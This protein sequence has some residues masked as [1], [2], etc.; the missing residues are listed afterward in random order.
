MC[1]LPVG[2][3][4]VLQY[5][6]IMNLAGGG[7][8]YGSFPHPPDSWEWF[9]C[10]GHRHFR[11]ERHAV[12]KFRL[13][14]G[15]S[16]GSV[17]TRRAICLHRLPLVACAFFVY[18]CYSRIA[19]RQHDETGLRCLV[20]IYFRCSVETLVVRW[21]MSTIAAW[22]A[23]CSPRTRGCLLRDSPTFR[24]RCLVVVGER[25]IFVMGVAD[26]DG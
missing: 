19:K 4:R 2:T 24:R 15:L 8:C 3:V 11:P 1:S 16:P 13:Q 23:H 9:C 17:T 12:V 20:A 7:C 22:K 6:A 5:A 10:T 14:V 21:S 26:A 25:G 18:L